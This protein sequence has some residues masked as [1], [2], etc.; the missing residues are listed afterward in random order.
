MNTDSPVLEILI[1]KIE[2]KTL[3]DLLPPCEE[4]RKLT[5][6]VVACDVAINFLKANS[7]TSRELLL[8]VPTATPA[9]QASLRDVA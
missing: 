5:L 1:T 2:A 4:R 8:R 7:E 6:K 3:V 9:V